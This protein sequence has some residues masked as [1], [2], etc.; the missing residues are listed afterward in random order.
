MTHICDSLTDKYRQHVK[1]K[2]KSRSGASKVK[3]EYSGQ[4]LLQN[5]V[6][7]EMSG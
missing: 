4:N 1:K 5:Y 6:K 7:F 3:V 2:K